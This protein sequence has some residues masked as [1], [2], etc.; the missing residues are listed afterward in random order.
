MPPKW[1]SADADG[2][3]KNGRGGGVVA[4]S[5]TKEV[6]TDMSQ[7]PSAPAFS[8]A[9]EDAG[10]QEDGFPFLLISSRHPPSH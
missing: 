9:K 7:F 3:Q 10:V 4:V 6:V 1:Q 5:P 8:D 2:S